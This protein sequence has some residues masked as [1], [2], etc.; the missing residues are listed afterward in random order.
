MEMHYLDSSN[1]EAAGYDEAT[2]TLVIE[3]KR[4]GTYEYFD[5]PKHIFEELIR[6]SSP[7]AFVNQYIK[8]VFRFSK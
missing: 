8:N 3:F 6:A 7:G 5:V 2:N 4:S 1:V